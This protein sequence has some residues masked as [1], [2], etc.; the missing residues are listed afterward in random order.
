[1]RRLFSRALLAATS[2]LLVAPSAMARV[3]SAW[4]SAFVFTQALEVPIYLV[5][6]RR[7]EAAGLSVDDALTPETLEDLAADGRPGAVPGRL[8]RP[9]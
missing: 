4:L 6:L 9:P 5:A 7:T 8:R 1:M 3:V 2:I